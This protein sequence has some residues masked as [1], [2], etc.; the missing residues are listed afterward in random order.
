ML[1]RRSQRN[2]SLEPPLKLRRSEDHNPCNVWRCRPTIV[3]AGAEMGTWFC[4]FLELLFLTVKL[5]R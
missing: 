1:L 3:C 4:E 5:I 2:R